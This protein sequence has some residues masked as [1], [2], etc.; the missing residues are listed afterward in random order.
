MV[1]GV[2]VGNG[3]RSGR[4]AQRPSLASH[5][6]SLLFGAPSRALATKVGLAVGICCLVVPADVR[7]ADALLGPY[8]V[9][10]FDVF[11]GIVP[12]AVGTICAA[13][14]RRISDWLNKKALI[15]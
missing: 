12:A 2:A 15:R 13:W 6:P 7:T 10:Q 1:H 14:M 3:F 5:F 8:A 11:Y 9:D 4:L